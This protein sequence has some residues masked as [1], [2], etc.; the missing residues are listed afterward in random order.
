MENN[1]TTKPTVYVPQF[2]LDVISG[3]TKA[4][5]IAKWGISA[6]SVKQIA[7]KFELTI[8]RAV[9]PKYIL[10]DDESTFT[11]TEDTTASVTSEV[12]TFFATAL[13]N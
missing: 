4:E 6:A 7:N 9:A 11:K 3:M 5:L 8:Q 12:N 10:V 2:K 13:N 1:K